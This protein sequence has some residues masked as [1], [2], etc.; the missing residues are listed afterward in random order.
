MKIASNFVF[1]VGNSTLIGA[2]T[3]RGIVKF[4]GAILRKPFSFF[5]NRL[6]T[7]ENLFKEVQEDYDRQRLE[8]FAKKYGGYFLLGALALV[9]GTAAVAAWQGVHD[10]RHQ[11]ATSALM[12][13]LNAKDL[14]AA[15][16]IDALENLA[17]QK[18]RAETQ[19]VLA[20]LHAAA[21]AAKQGDT[22]KALQIYNSVANDTD[23]DTL[24][25]QFGDLMAVWIQMDSADPATLQGRL[26]PL[27]ADKAAWRFSAMELDSFLSLRAGH[28]EKARATFTELSQNADVPRSLA[29]RAEDM[30]RYV[31]E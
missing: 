3:R 23:A 2:R 31:S 18:N 17:N 6:M 22:A 26:M 16:Q 30:L 24:F 15:K 27:M 29:A 1:Q 21:L 20:H 8:A 11:K 7:D 19:T 5:M 10:E 4:S 12:D 14:G 25:R 13:I 9:L 28:T